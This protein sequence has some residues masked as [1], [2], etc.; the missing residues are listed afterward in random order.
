[1]KLIVAEG[2]I[3]YREIFITWS[4]EYEKET[5]EF[6][7]EG[8]ENGE[9]WVIR[10]RMKSRGNAE[11]VTE[12]K[13]IDKKDE[14]LRYYRIRKLSRNGAEVLK[15]FV[16][17]DYSIQVSMEAM[18]MENQ[19]SLVMEY[20]VDQDQELIARIYNQFGEQVTTK[21]MPFSW[22]GDFIF[23]LDIS[24]LEEG[25]YL[26]VVTQVLSD[27]VVAESPFRIHEE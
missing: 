2:R 22:A 10:G 27:K 11:N 14:T 3:F 18:I 7:I 19:K 4:T 23:H 15:K 1:M 9:D 13:F 16:L 5:C 26:L 24:D 21:V 8:S 17:E 20:T 12:Y 6:I 25:S